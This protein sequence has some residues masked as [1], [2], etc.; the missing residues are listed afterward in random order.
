LFRQSEL[1]DWSELAV[2]V[3]EAL[4]IRALSAV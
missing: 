1:D 2:R 3:A 4:K